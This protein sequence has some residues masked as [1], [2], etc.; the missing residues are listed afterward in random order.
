MPS[1]TPPFARSQ[2]DAPRS[3]CVVTTSYPSYDGDPAGH[4][5]KAEV[6]ELE[7]AGHRVTVVTPHAGGAFGWPGA[8]FRL[9]EKPWRAF[10]SA[11][12]M[13]RA[14]TQVKGARPDR[15]IAHWSVPSAFPVVT[16]AALYDV[17]L[18]V[19]SHGGDIRLLAASP[20]AVRLSVVR[21]L[22]RRAT[23]WRFV[24]EP[25][26]D[27]LAGTLDGEDA[28]KL[29]AMSVIAPS[30]L[31]MIDVR[32]E[33]RARRNAVGKRPLFVCAGRLVR[34]KRV[35]RVIDYVAGQR[36]GHPVLV[37][38]GDGPERARLEKLA[39]EWQID[40]RFLGN[41]PRREALAWIG[42]ADELVHASIA[43]GISTVVR[44][45][46]HLGVKVTVL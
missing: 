37:V 20:R 4:F 42:A 21:R 16:S 15:I 35:D 32:E 22:L 33:V 45:A 39:R 2:D 44:E 30:P 41:T 3:I 38:I 34:S 43:E 1:D 18:E 5:V 19:V 13:V 24:S 6:T 14:A 7:N 46:E 31:A 40:V 26:L 29:R 17:P 11:A 25:L 10:E 36:V 8:A 12:W 9:R 23:T 27:R 28:A